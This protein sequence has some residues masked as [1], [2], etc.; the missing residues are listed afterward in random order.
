M[1][2]RVK[3]TMC[4]IKEYCVKNNLDLPNEGQEYKTRKTPYIFMC[5][6]HGEYSMS[7]DN[8]I[9]GHG[10][11]E[12]KK[13]TLREKRKV[14]TPQD[15]HN[16]CKT[17]SYLY[18]IDD[19][20]NN[21][22]PI[23]HECLHCGYIFKTKPNNVKSNSSGCP[24]CTGRLGIPYK[25]YC[26][27]CC[28]VHADK[29]YKIK[30]YYRGYNTELF[31]CSYC[32]KLYTNNIYE[33]VRKDTKRAKCPYCQNN[34]Q[35]RGELMVM[36]YLDS[37]HINYEYPKTFDDF[38]GNRGYPYHFD[39]YLPSCNTLIEYQG[40]QHYKAMS[41]LGGE[42]KFEKRKY[43]DNLKRDYCKDKGYRLVEVP[44]TINTQKL[45]NDY[46]KKINIS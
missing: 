4:K 1:N 33:H 14:Y 15:Y 23:K 7:W 34:H 31:K 43:I 9:K 11:K 2:K 8:H 44:Y 19:Y 36:N 16:W 18:P 6:K 13:E 39:F 30:W 20:V 29:P 37:N 27:M 12:C 32:G 38:T 3:W 41:Y 21:S 26:K 46:L 28:K 45:I 5:P 17:N 25:I 35:S 24:K 10:C 42:E 40:E 22:T